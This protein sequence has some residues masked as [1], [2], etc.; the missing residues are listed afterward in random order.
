MY[1]YAIV[2]LARTLFEQST[3][4]AETAANMSKSKSKSK[5][6]FI[7]NWIVGFGVHNTGLYV[8]QCSRRGL[9]LS[10]ERGRMIRDRFPFADFYII[11]T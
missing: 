9:P 10:K 4:A 11:R 5:I 2:Y 1:I 8:L 7:C 3:L 6:R